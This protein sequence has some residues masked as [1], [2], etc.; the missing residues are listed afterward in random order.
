[1]GQGAALEDFEDSRL[2][3]GSHL[4][5]ILCSVLGLEVKKKWRVFLCTAWEQGK[6]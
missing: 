4:R 5:L 2:A 3:F 6:S 1:M